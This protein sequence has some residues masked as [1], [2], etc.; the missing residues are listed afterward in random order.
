MTADVVIPAYNDHQTIA[1]ATASALALPF[2]D[3]VIIVDDGSAQP[4]TFAP[5]LAG[6]PRLTLIRQPNRGPSVAR[7]TGI[8]ASTAPFVIFCDA[9]DELLPG[10]EQSLSLASQTGAAATVSGRVMRAVDGSERD[11]LPPAEWRDRLLPRPGDVY[12]PI[13]LFGTPGLILPRRVIDAGLR[14][15]PAIRHGQ[16]RDL[17]RRAAEL[18]PVA[19]SSA[20]AVRYYARADGANVSG[21]K[22]IHQRTRDF[23]LVMSRHYEPDCREHWAQAAAWRQ[24][25]Y[26]KHGVD[27]ALWA[28]LRQEAGRRGLPTPTKPA[29]RY[30][31]RRLVRTLMGSEQ[32]R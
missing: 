14:F 17:I 15:D 18:G 26:S 10:V 3:R 12:R 28:Q 20:L 2:V 27:D 31:L 19:V 24:N 16:D 13:W 5:P 29:V 6:D 7:N 21:S 22:H 32:G 1:R 23:L 25:D 8:D 11:A 4:I 9:D 30:A